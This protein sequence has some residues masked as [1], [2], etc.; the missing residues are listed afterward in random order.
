M[1]RNS[2]NIPN[3]KIDE[4]NVIK[5]YGMGQ[6]LAIAISWSLHKHVGWAVFHGFFGWAYVLFYWLSMQ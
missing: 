5:V 2:I 3:P 4:A 6:A 1:K